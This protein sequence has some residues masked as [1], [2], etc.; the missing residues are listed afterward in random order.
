MSGPQLDLFAPEFAR[1][2][3]DTLWDTVTMTNQD[4]SKFIGTYYSN[5]I[6]FRQALQ[7]TAAL[8]CLDVLSQ[9]ISK[10]TLRLK[11]RL[12]GGGE[13]I[14]EPN[15]HPIA[16]MLALDPNARH[17]WP[18]YVGMMIYA[19][20]M[21]CNAYSYIKRSNDTTPTALIPVVPG[22][23]RER[24]YR[25]TGEVF[26]DLHASSLQELALLGAESI[27][28]PERDVLHIRHR[29]MDGFWGY[30]TLTAGSRSIKLA[31]S[32][33]DYQ[34]QLF[35]E[36]AMG[37]G[38]FSR[39]SASGALS[40]AAFARAKSQ[41]K[42]LMQR[43][44]GE[45]DEPILLEDGI[46][47]DKLAFSAADA[48][49]VKALNSAVEAI[50]Q[51]WRMPPHKAMH[52][53]AVKYENLTAMEMVYVR[54]TLL[55]IC[56]MFEARLA[57]MLLTPKE[58]LQFFFEFDRDEMTVADEKAETDR[59]LR[60]AERGVIMVNEARQKLRMNPAPWG[61]TR[62]VP[63]NTV[64]VDENN[65]VVVSGAKGAADK[66]NADQA[67]ADQAD[68]PAKSAPH[69]RLVNGD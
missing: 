21:A 27:T 32:I 49:V 51:L 14:V 24:I 58:R 5:T 9:D 26:Y 53:T 25:V 60:A 37:R 30:S 50:C 45:G 42:K 64:L 55:P 22:Q 12:K 33:E 59:T 11:E 44:R 39:E 2:L 28:A 36:N 35:N 15:S 13:Q 40:D 48:E 10:A 68:Q 66:T 62:I 34:A 47:F 18:E 23:V 19:L 69:L 20:G 41:L 31:R 38:V 52:L 54:D 43:V 61:N 16:M 6:P 1:E 17:T 3:G 65:N 56:R 46:K 4:W 7:Q 67:N 63:V 57:R 29:M 8:I